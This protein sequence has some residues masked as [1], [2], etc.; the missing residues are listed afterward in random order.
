MPFAELATGATLYYDDAGQGEA[1]ILLHG[2]LGNAQVHFS[3]VI[4]W[5]KGDYRLIGPTARG[6]GQSLPRP[7]DFPLNFYHQDADD[8]LAFMDALKLGQ[9]HLLGYSDGG[10]S[11]LVAAGKQPERFKSVAVI[12]AVGNFDPAIRPRIQRMFPADWISAEERARNGIENPDAF[13]LPWINAMKHII[14]SGGDI[15]LSLAHR[16]TCPL[17]IMLGE[18]DSLNPPTY[19]RKFLERTPNGQLAMFAGGHGVHEE[20]WPR[21]QAVYGAFLRGQPIPAAG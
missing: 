7:R 16:I 3:Q 17:L 15:S 9:A 8:V 6:Y 2:L 19:A 12:G 4:D 13:I 5:L 20:Q 1:L 11:A 21:F 18:T 14:D 10:E